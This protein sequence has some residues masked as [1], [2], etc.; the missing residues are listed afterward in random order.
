MRSARTTA[1]IAALAAVA[2]LLVVLIWHL[3]HQPHRAKTGESAPAFV[4]QRLDRDD[5]LD[6]S[7]LRGK[8]VVLNFWASWC[9]PCKREA[10][11]LEQTWQAGRKRGLVV[12]G[13][14]ANDR[15]S[16]AR[17]F[18]R[19]HGITYPVVRDSNGSIAANSYNVSDLPMTFFINRKGLIVGDGIRGA[20]GDE[21]YRAAFRRG[22]EAALGS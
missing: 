2:G 16:D 6:L 8:G 15:D 3:T 14:D 17:R 10:K 18:M 1:Q 20:V 7:T 4:L 11:T 12:I 21:Q 9:G 5:V 13:V 19:A 22:I